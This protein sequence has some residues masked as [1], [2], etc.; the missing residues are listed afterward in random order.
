M[1]GVSL[2]KG[3]ER[4]LCEAVKVKSGLPWRPQEAKDARALGYQQRKAVNR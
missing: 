2:H 4:L 1:S 3:S